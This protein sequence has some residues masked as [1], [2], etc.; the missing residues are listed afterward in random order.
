MDR[1]TLPVVAFV[2]AG[3]RVT[4]VL[5]RL[6]ANACAAG[7]G[8]IEIHVIDPHP[9]GAG[10]IWRRAQSRL[11]WMNSVARDVTLFTDESVAIDGP[12]RPGP[13]LAQW[14]AGPGAGRLAAN[15]IDPA[16]TALG[17][18][19]FVPREVAG[20]YLA[21]A[22]D[23]AAAALPAGSRVHRHADR[24]V[25]VTDDVEGR[26]RI[27]LANRPSVV[28]DVVVLAQG[29]LDRSPEPDQEKL[30]E[31]AR[32][33]GATYLPP[34]YTADLDLSA[35]GA[36]QPVL[37]RG[38]GLAFIDLMVLLTQGRGGRYDTDADGTLR[39]RPSGAEPQVIV[40]SRRGVPY[41][42]KLGYP[43][44]STEP[45]LPEYLPRPGSFAAG[46]YDYQRDLWP[47]IDAELRT[48]HY[49]RL[50]TAHR[51]R[52]RGGWPEL[53]AA[54]ES[55]GP[56]AAEHL[57]RQVPD[58]RDRFDV[59]LLDRP[60]AGR[61]WSDQH[62]AELAVRDH[63]RDDLRRRADP[64]YSADRAVF[65]R[66][67]TVYG[68]LAAMTAAGAVSTADRVRHVEGDFHSLFSFLA[69]GPPPRRLAELLAL[70]EA[71]V[72]RF[73]GPDLRITPVHAG[74]AASTPAAPGSWTAGTLVDARLPRTDA[75]AVT[76]PL[77][78]GLLD[79]G[80]LAHGDGKL[81][82]DNGARAVRADG[83]AHPRRYLLGP[84]VAGSAGSAG[85]ARPGF[86]A[87][88]LR[89]NDAVARD[90]LAQLLAAADRPAIR[91]APVLAGSH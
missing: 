31:H 13:T 38:F 50:F 12:R 44:A 47:L 20:H 86:N 63:I 61:R 25:E 14:I 78:R 7:S 84:S 27:R 54:L 51:E 64:A 76:D 43:S 9:P 16:T 18:D 10:R 28:A 87:P 49:R 69:S 15:G 46:G 55:G 52:T 73:A 83:S 33:T 6:S 41:H 65:D 60:L 5:E 89:Q 58:P 56:A 68:T 81:L 82:A 53:R 74:F 42:A 37:V 11:L 85:F 17:G 79:T 59:A 8:P 48:V 34:G 2:G 32:R 39:Y 77:L 71:G 72:V 36:G 70:N 21:W 75:S 45:S 66:L 67:L 19:D 30:A 90:M 24:A 3:P 57:R 23:R 22:F 1:G 29:Y 4:S 80:E 26:Q 88:S 91:R 62:T 40:G 35:L